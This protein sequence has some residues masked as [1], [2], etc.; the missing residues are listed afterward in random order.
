MIRTLVPSDAYHLQYE[1]QQLL[2][3]A[4]KPLQESVTS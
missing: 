3:L 2:S 1:I 4:L